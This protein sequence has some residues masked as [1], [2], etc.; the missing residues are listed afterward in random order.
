M[1]ASSTAAAA[2]LLD[3]R[4][5]VLYGTALDDRALDASL[6]VGADL[7]LTDSNRRRIE[8][9]FYSIKDTRGPTEREGETQ[10]DPTGYDFRLDPFPGAT[11]ASRTVALQ[12]GGE[13]G[14]HG[15]RRAGAPGGAGGPR[16]GR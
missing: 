5:L 7:I 11:D 14:G 16:G 1:R 8:T 12:I 3:G 4:S 15:R 10:P 2:G 9:W 13:V 6:E